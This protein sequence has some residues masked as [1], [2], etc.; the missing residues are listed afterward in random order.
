MNYGFKVVVWGNVCG[1]TA[2]FADWG[3]DV[4]NVEEPALLC[5]GISLFLPLVADS[6]IYLVKMCW[7]IFDFSWCLECSFFS[8]SVFKGVLTSSLQY[9]SHYFLYDEPVCAWTNFIFLT[10]SSLYA[11]NRQKTYFALCSSSSKQGSENG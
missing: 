8:V 5:S 4:I 7:F 6:A 1:W 3:S 10:L 2:L 9:L 11:I